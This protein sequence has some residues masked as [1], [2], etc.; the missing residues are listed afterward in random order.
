MIRKDGSQ[1]LS[2]TKKRVAVAYGAKDPCP[3]CNGT[4][5]VPSPKNP[6]NKINCCRM[7]MTESGPAKVKTCDGTGL[8][9]DGA[10]VPRTEKDGVGYGRDVLTESGDELLIGLAEHQEDAKV[11]GTYVPF[12]RR[13]RQPI[14]G[15]MEGCPLR[16]SDK[17]E[18]SCPGPYRDIPLTLWP[19]VLVETGRTAYGGVIQQF[20]RAPGRWVEIE[21]VDGKKRIYVPSLREC[22]VARPGHWLGSCDYE[23]GE[24]VTWAQACIYLVGRSD[25]ATALLSGVKPHDALGA[26][27]MGMGYEEFLRRRKAKDR[28]CV[29]IRQ[30]SKPTNFGVPGGMGDAKMALT[31][32]KQGPDTPCENGPHWIIDEAT[33]KPIRG[34]KGLRFC[35]LMDKAE[36]C[37]GVKVTEWNDRRI[38]PTCRACI[39]CCKRLR[40]AWN[41]QWSEGKAYFGYINECIDEGMLITAE[42]LERWPWLKPWFRPNE[43]LAPGE[44]MQLVSG[45]VRGGADYCA[46]ANGFFQGLLADAAKSALRRASRECYDRTLRIPPMAHPNSRPSAYGG[47]ES[48]M[49]G[50]RIIVFQHD[51]VIPEVPIAQA[52]DSMMRLSEIMVEELMWYCPDLR[53]ACAAEPALMTR[54][55]KGAIPWWRD[56]GKKR[57]GPDDRLVPWEPK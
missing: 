54:W 29:D 24:L 46:L 33:Q 27:T 1:D 47:L 38:P 26:T 2:T 28:M 42:M 48:P 39:E 53:D 22:I 56:G 40:A 9:L 57:K 52:H 23:T 51:E 7:D 35:I 21:T 44:V 15:H 20:P 30:A 32:R 19:N 11:L 18:C 50:S 16:T 14:A 37:G 4:G 43:R 12:L 3:V 34:Y 36:S 6:K 17:G 13:A 31:Q 49:L 10:E 41:R 45:R 25:L 8:Q 55:L 5:K